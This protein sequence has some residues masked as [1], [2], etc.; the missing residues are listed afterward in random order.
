M[1]F[2]KYF[3]KS[4]HFHLDWDAIEPVLSI[5]SFLRVALSLP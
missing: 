3:M 4:F 1:H 2:Y 5:S